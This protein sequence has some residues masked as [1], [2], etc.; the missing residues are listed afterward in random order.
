MKQAKR[1]RHPVDHDAAYAARVYDLE[2][3]AMRELMKDPRSWE[4]WNAW[5]DSG[6]PVRPAP[7][8]LAGW[9]MATMGACPK[10]RTSSKAK[11]HSSRV[12]S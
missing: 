2:T 8:F 4:A 5:L 12:R 11:A 10:T 1:P 6:D 7:A 9:R 3:D